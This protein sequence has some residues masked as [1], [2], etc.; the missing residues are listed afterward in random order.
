MEKYQEFS[1]FSK[2]L[3][4]EVRIFTMVPKNYDA[5][6]K[7]Y[8]VLYMHDGKNL[9]D[10]KL[11]AYGKSWGI[12]EAFESYPNLPELIIIG[13]DNPGEYRS[14][15]LVPFKFKFSNSDVEYGGNTDSYFDFITKSLKPLIDEKF[16]TKKDAHNTGLMGSSFGGVAS[17]YAAFKYSDYFS[18]FGCVSNAYYVVQKQFEEFAKARNLENVQ[19]FYMDVGTKETSNDIDNSKYIESNR[20]MFDILSNRIEKDKIK[21]VI[22]KDAIHNEKDW[23]IRFP[24]IIDFMF[25]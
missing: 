4:R 1:I 20:K 8:P 14:H 10:D 21:F 13:V 15:D 23:E 12:L 16:R 5:S 19:R 22:A 6:D 18:R 17:T 11:A 3:N 24:E 7:N 9:F 2:E 25:N